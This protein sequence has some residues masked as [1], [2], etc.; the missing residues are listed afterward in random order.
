MESESW[1]LYN[2][3]FVPSGDPVIRADSRA[4]RYGDGCFETFRSQR[5]SLLHLEHH[6]ERLRGGLK[7]L[8]IAYPPQLDDAAI[9]EAVAAL[10]RRNGLM[11]R[12][13][14]VRL[15][16]WREGGRGYRT[17]G[18]EEVEYVISCG[19]L[20]P[21]KQAWE[22]VTSATRRIPG[23]AL[24]SRFKWS[25]GTNLILASREAHRNGADDALML[26]V[27]GWISETTMANIFWT[28]GERIYTPDET[29]DLLPGI[30]RSMLLSLLEEG[31]W[32]AVRPG[33]YAPGELRGA[34]AAWTCNSLR[35][36]MPVSR[37]D[38]Y[39]LDPAYPLIGQLRKA[40]AE[41]FERNAQKL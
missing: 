7:Q 36:V 19:E 24:P 10:L 26:S 21:S 6:L 3:R 2:G 29:C 33:R 25:G 35:G 39:S 13:A 1:V 23:D 37:V 32:P 5:G 12:P 17:Q 4:V 11:D 8:G 40:Y 31:D 20:P 34:K 30:T 18:M 16:V 27:E 15:Q 22:L 14:G 38:G 41:Y 9:G 28:D